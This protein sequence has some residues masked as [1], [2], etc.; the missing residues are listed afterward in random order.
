[1]NSFLGIPKLDA[2]GSMFPGQDC[3]FEL[4]ATEEKIVGEL[5]RDHPAMLQLYNAQQSSAAISH[6]YWRNKFNGAVRRTSL[7]RCLFIAHE[8]PSLS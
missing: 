7:F 6:S 4:F 2:N 8:L 3:M 5:L 1:M